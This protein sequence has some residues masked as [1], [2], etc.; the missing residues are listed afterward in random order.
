MQGSVDFYTVLESAVADLI[1]EAKFRPKKWL[2]QPKTCQYV[3]VW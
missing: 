3:D 2:K 1:F